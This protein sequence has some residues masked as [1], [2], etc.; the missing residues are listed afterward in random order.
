MAIAALEAL[1]EFPETNLFLRGL[2][3][4]LGFRSSQ[5]FYDRKARMAGETKYPLRRMVGLGLDGI[6]SFSAVPLRLIAENAAF[7]P[8]MVG[9]VPPGGI[10]THIVGIDLIRTGPGEFMVLEDNARTPSGVSYMLENRETMMAMFP[11]LFTRIAVRQVSDYPRRLARSLAACAPAC[12][13][14]VASIRSPT[15]SWGVQA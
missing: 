6:T 12:A 1:S 3:P 2:V 15:A 8:Q 9:L 14:A 5:V 4:Q 7:L 10:Y 13:G 11:E